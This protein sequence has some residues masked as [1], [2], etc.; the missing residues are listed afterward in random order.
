MQQPPEQLTPPYSAIPVFPLTFAVEYPDRPL[1][2]L[3]TALRFLWIIPI[4]I[5]ASLLTSGQ[6]SLEGNDYS[7]SWAAVGM[8][9]LPV[10][11][12]ILFRQKYPR[13]WFDWNLNLTKFLVRVGTYAQLLRDE[14]PVHRRGAGGLRRLPLSGRAETQPLAA[15]GQVVPRHPP[16]D[17]P[18]VPM[19]GGRRS[20]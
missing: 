8:L 13:W 2:R 1:N 10:L 16:L 20:A 12:M 11:L 18:G 7:W 5:I 14:Y 15:A 3:S 6:I 19:A 17:R 4:G 9:V